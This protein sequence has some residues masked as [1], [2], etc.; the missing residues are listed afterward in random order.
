MWRDVA[1]GRSAAEIQRRLEIEYGISS[2]V[3]HADVYGFLAELL[4]RKLMRRRR[5]I[6][7]QPGRVVG[8]LAALI[9]LFR[10][11]L[12]M[13]LGGFG[14][15][16]A[17]LKHHP[18]RWC[19]DPEGVGAAIQAAAT[20]ACSLYWKPA[21]CLQR[22][23]MLVRLLR[24]AG[25]PAELVIGYRPTPFFSHAWVELAGRVLNDSPAYAR[26]LAVLHRV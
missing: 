8:C 9:E 23:V 11:D 12:Q 20:L 25:I 2:S 13:A 22:S 16:Q 10:Y 4:R 1:A 17:G 26:R 6:R 15:I 18:V 24:R 5:P 14:R 7:T 19:A 3:A 21:R